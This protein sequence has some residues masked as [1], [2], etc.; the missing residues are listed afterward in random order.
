M[1]TSSSA[2]LEQIAAG[3]VANR[4]VLHLEWCAIIDAAP[5]SS[6]TSCRNLHLEQSAVRKRIDAMRS[7]DELENFYTTEG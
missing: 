7:R 3:S 6:N 2:W 5:T 4:W 1:S